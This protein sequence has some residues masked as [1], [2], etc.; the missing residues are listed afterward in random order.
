[1]MILLELKENLK[2]LYARFSVP[3]TALIRFML[4]FFTLWV[5]NSNL[6]F[7]EQMDSIV[8]MAVLSLVCAI[9]PYGAICLVMA[10]VLLGHIYMVSL[11]IALLTAAFMVIVTLLYYG[12]QPGD[13]YWLLLTPLAFFLKIPYAIPLLAGLSGTLIGIFPVGFGIVIY[14]IISY[15]KQNAGV[16]TNDTTADVTQKCVQMLRAMIS[17]HEMMVFLA[18]CAAGILIV[19]LVR[20]LSVDYA[21]IIAIALGT[22]G[23]FAVVFV[24]DIFL[25]VT[26]S[27]GNIL[28]GML[29]SVAIAGVY[30]FFVF[31]VDY[32]RTEFMQFEDDDYVYYVKAVPKVAVSKSDVR[33]QRMN[34]PRGFRRGGRQD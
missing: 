24:G 14:Y 6:G 30:H 31:A 7:M 13:S 20:T 10:A 34:N 29:I 8:V 1:M 9:L 25:D 19:Y 12:F 11:E 26:L 2:V 17:N 4:S 21:W 27:L 22:I 3:V 28:I 16:L 15:V 33:V 5:L 23:Q 32:S 18:A